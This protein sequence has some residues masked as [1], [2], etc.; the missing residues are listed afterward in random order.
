MR[1]GPCARFT[2][3]IG[4]VA[5]GLAGPDAAFADETRITVGF[6][7]AQAQSPLAVELTNAGPRHVLPSLRLSG[8]RSGLQLAGYKT[9]LPPLVLRGLSVAPR[10][11]D[12][13]LAFDFQPSALAGLALSPRSVRGLTLAATAKRL[14]GTLLVGRLVSGPSM[15]P[16][17]SAIPRVL[18]FSATMKPQARISISPRLVTP[19]GR[20]SAQ[21]GADPT[22]GIGMR[23]ELSRHISVIGDAGSTRTQDR[24]AAANGPPATGRWAPLATGGAFGRWSR[25]S[26]EASASHADE[27]ATL[28]GSVPFAALNRKLA[29]ARVLLLR[30]VTAEGQLSAFNPV[31]RPTDGTIQRAATFRID[32][33]PYGKMVV[34]FDRSKTHTRTPHAFA[35]EWRRRAD[36]A[37]A[38][39]LQQRTDGSGSSAGRARRLHIE[40]PSLPKISRRLTLGLQSSVLLSNRW[41]GTSRATT[42]LKGRV[43][44]GSHIAVAGD[45]ELQMLGNRPLQRL[46][47]LATSTEILL[48]RAASI[49]VGH[50]YVP[51]DRTHLWKRIEIRFT[52]TVTS[53]K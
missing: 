34:Q 15:S 38:I 31:R 46:S 12:Q 3:V 43:A 22:M 35:I 1:K 21:D 40:M 48:S 16:F 8:N 42:H 50:A 28:L 49:T 36:N 45:A 33:L 32:R 27:G 4:T 26:L 39:Q 10:Y 19:L 44:A 11:G 52:K 53:G 20:R 41:P 18:A 47:R 30:G 23:A 29:S 5:A 2:A 37:I 9:L 6:R 24:R 51:N 25:V 7:P 14:S 13:Q 17:G